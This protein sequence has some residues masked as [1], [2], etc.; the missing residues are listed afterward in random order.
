MAEI[1]CA[2]GEIVLIDDKD[3][4]WLNT[5]CWHI[6]KT[7]PNKDYLYARCSIGDK[8]VLMH[9]LILG[10]DETQKVDHENGNGL[11]NRRH[12]IRPSTHAQN[13]Q[14]RRRLAANVS[15]YKGVYLDRSRPNAKWRAEIKANGQKYRLGSYGSAELAHEAYKAA[16]LRLH[17]EF[18]TEASSR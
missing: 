6:L 2:S 13:M 3:F 10:V 1:R 8:E 15:G 12:N 5:R 9:R 14:N 11:D 7:G 17:M 18:S 16:S 4:H